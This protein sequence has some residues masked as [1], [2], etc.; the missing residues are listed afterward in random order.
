V[1]TIPILLLLLLLLL[2]H[3]ELQATLSRFISG[4]SYLCVQFAR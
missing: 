2:L 4:V 3:S 1:S